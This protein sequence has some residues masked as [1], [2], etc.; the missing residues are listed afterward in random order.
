[1]LE[2]ISRAFEGLSETDQDAI[3]EYVTSLSIKAAE[4]GGAVIRGV[5]EPSPGSE[6]GA[7]Q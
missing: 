3:L 7:A 2:K 6:K 5:G 4:R 1:M